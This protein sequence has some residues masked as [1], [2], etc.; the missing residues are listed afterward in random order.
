MPA[1]DFAADFGPFGDRI[2]LNCSHQGPIPRV[3]AAAAEAA[4]AMKLAPFQMVER[5]LFQDVPLRLRE[6]LGRLIHVP[7][8]DVILGNSTSYGLTL[9][10]RGLDWRA[11]DEVLLVEGDFPAAIFPWLV[12][13]RLGVAVRRLQPSG[14]A[15][16]VDD[17]ARELRPRT[18]VFCTTWVHSFRG[19]ALDVPPLSGVCRA[20]G[21]LF[22]L[23]ASQGVGA[24]P[25][26]A[27]ASGVD[28]VT[29]CG[30]KYLCGPYGTGFSWIRPELRES[31]HAPKGYWLA[32]LTAD[33]LA[34]SFTAELRP[35][36]GAR[37][38]DVSG[39]AN[40]FNVM[41]WTAAVEYL[42]SHGID[43]I[44]AWDQTLVS[45]LVEGLR[46]QGWTMVSPPDGPARTTLTVFHGASPDHT[47]S[48]FAALRA[49][50]VFGSMR[51]GNVRLSP[52]LFNT[53]NDID[54]AL[55]ALAGPSSA[56]IAHPP[57]P[58]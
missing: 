19:H 16:S 43:R 31:L 50:G 3:A 4:V 47:A 46:D 54:A 27:I 37:A 58:I 10:A 56:R 20:N 35:D 55:E 25:F 9:L 21:T 34:G 5:G 6:A 2:W 39:T 17:L 28:M 41:T 53:T 52:H 51:Q 36:V 45:R 32:N 30:F 13:E 49:R 33:D 1:P 14:P 15:L 23:N 22:A 18:R 40:F 26:D 7:A 29:S 24:R 11:G 12:L 38:F 8:D 44:A 48:A 57:P 42:V